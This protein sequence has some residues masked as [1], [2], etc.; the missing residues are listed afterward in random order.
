MQ[1]VG[2]DPAHWRGRRVFVTGHTG[3]FGGWL[4]LWLARLGAEVTGYALAPPTEP[5]F[6]DSVGLGGLVRSVV[7][8]IRDGERLGA[9][10]TA[11]TFWAI[12]RFLVLAQEHTDVLLVALP[13]ESPEKGIHSDKTTRF[14]MEQE[15]T[16]ARCQAG[17][18]RINRDPLLFCGIREETPPARV[19]GLSPRV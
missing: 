14:S 13:L 12:V 15:S 2:I 7:A 18:W 11:T 10:P 19:P 6:F 3:F 8:D 5:S 16:L 1:T 9:Q 17:P 4:S